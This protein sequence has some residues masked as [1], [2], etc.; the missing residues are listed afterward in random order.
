VIKISS[1]DEKPETVT[2]IEWDEYYTEGFRWHRDGITPFN[3]T[4]TGRT[5]KDAVI[6]DAG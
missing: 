4:K 5:I 2:L 6:T 1:I 3:A